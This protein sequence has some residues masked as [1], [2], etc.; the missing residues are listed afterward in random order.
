[1]LKRCIPLVG[2]S[3]YSSNRESRRKELEGA[4]D[5]RSSESRGKKEVK[6][7]RGASIS[8]DVRLQ[9]KNIYIR[10]VHAGGR[11]ELYP[12][13][14]PASKLME[15]YPGMSVA[16]PEVF[17][18]PHD[19]L[20]CPE[21]SLLPGQKYHVVPSSTVHKLRKKAEV[22]EHVAVKKETWDWKITIDVGEISLEYSIC[23][24]KDFYQSKDRTEKCSEDTK[25]STR[26][27]VR[28]KKPFVP[29]LPKGKPFRGLGWE[30]SLT[31]VP[32]L[33]P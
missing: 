30:P 12:N 32:E 7:V 18:S 23:Y 3:R 20:L 1:M 29:P 26:N 31:S 13:A 27:R 22:K 2:F 9:G 8:L 14:I 21:D 25:P 10:I 15:K 5:D 19:F 11:E 28:G 4:S 33:S 17:K 16:R 6:E 24:A